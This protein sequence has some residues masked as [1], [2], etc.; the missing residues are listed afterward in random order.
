MGE[1]EWT[2]GIWFFYVEIMLASVTV[3]EVSLA[4][5]EISCSY[6]GRDGHTEE[7]R[8]YKK[9]AIMSESGT[10]VDTL[11]V[12]LAYLDQDFAGACL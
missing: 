6:C 10:N 8:W 11:D 1:E 2:G 5:L 4:E 12:K 3:P 9:Q 7:Q